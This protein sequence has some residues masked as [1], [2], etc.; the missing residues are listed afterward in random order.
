MKCRV[1]GKDETFESSISIQA[2]LK[3]KGLNHAAVVIE[4]NFD[5]PEREKWDSIMLKEDDNLEIV[6]FIGGG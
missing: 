1:N 6:K 2:F 5:I 4:Y 3:L